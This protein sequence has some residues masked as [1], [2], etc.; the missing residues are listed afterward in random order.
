MSAGVAANATDE[1]ARASLKAA[2]L[3]RLADLR[4]RQYARLAAMKQRLRSLAARLQNLWQDLGGARRPVPSKMHLRATATVEKQLGKAE[5]LLR[6]TED[7]LVPTEEYLMQAEVH[8]RSAKKHLEATEA[9][10]AP[11]EAPPMS[12][13]K[14][15]VGALHAG[16][17]AE[18]HWRQGC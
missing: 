4:A 2:Y 7:C 18:G 15:V 8:L 17:P 16:E 9:Q 13:V 1:E 10:L 14:A 12:T 3:A 6:L 11:V 5:V